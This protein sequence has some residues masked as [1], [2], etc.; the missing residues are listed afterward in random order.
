MNALTQQRIIRTCSQ[1]LPEKLKDRYL[2]VARIELSFPDDGFC[3]ETRMQ[4]RTT[5]INGAN[6]LGNDAL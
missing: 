3:F 4:V 2:S 6:H 5:D 1:T